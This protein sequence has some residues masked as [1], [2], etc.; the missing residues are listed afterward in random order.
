M[1]YFKLIESLKSVFESDARIKTITEGDID[2]LDLYRQ[3]IPAMAHIIISDGTIQDNLNVYNVLIQ[4]V[5]IV[6]E[7][8]NI[9]S[10]KFKGN[11]NRQEV[12]NDMDN[13]LRRAYLTFKRDAEQDNINV[14]GDASVTKI[15]EE[16]TENNLAGW[17]A[18]FTVE[19]PNELMDVCAPI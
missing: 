5:D 12:Y 14:L 17:A 18:T 8:N 7:N 19:V 6:S 13:V 11:D 2:D 9:T 15:L 1:S 10:E 16:T 4:C 3:N